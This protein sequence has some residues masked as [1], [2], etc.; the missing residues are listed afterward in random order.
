MS[1]T[2]VVNFHIS[3]KKSITTVN[4]LKV[5]EGIGDDVLR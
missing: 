3:N 4:A 1:H 5:T 2:T